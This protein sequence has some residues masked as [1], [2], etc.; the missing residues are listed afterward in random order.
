[1]AEIRCRVAAALG[2]PVSCVKLL[3][4]GKALDDTA[5]LVDID[6]DNIIT[7]VLASPGPFWYPTCKYLHNYNEV[8]KITWRMDHDR[9][10][11]E[12]QYCILYTDGTSETACDKG[13]VA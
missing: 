2:V 7:T 9:G 10:Y 13:N 1:M 6:P 5:P 8:F 4:G 12:Y 11:K 3:S